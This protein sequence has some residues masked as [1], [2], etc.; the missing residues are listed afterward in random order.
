MRPF[1][2]TLAFFVT[3]LT[4][5]S[6]S[7]QNAHD[8][9]SYEPDLDLGDLPRG[10]PATLYT[11]SGTITDEFANP[12]PYVHVMLLGNNNYL[13]TY[14]DQN[15]DYQFTDIEGDHRYT[16]APNRY[17]YMRV[18]DNSQVSGE[19]IMGIAEAELG[20]TDGESPGRYH[21]HGS[22]W[23][24]EFVSWVYWQAGEPFTGGAGD[25]GACDEEWNMSATYNVVA[26]FGRDADWQFLSIDEIDDNWP[27]GS[28]VPL[29]PQPGD[30]V[31]FS[32][33]SGIDRAHSG[34]VDEIV[35]PDMNTIEGN[36]DNVV[37]AVTRS[38]WRTNQSGDPVVK[39][40]GYRRLVSQISFNPRFAWYDLTSSQI[41]NFVQIRLCRGNI[42][43][44]PPMTVAEGVDQTPDHGVLS[45]EQGH[46]NEVLTVSR[47]MEIRACPGPVV[48]GIP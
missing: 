28:D 30:Y 3:A 9:Y 21:G 33:E 25:L 11:I 35:G 34:L 5:G 48:I 26:G 12:I 45:I 46:Y 29:E 17:E 1:A 37:A 47:P 38:N 20:N 31:L 22:K 32:N 10:S 42:H 39:G 15:G 8:P 23:C 16:V 7:A 36:V 19:T 13:T 24:S 6:A 4:V 41:A 14:T 44:A 40:I 43:V 2:I 18:I 27:G